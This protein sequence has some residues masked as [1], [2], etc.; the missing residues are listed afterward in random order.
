MIKQFFFMVCLI[1]ITGSFLLLWES[2][3]ESFSRPDSSK[4]EELP[5]ADSYMRNIKS[6]IFSL[7]G[8][9]QYALEAS[10]I[11]IFSGISELKLARP[12]LVA[13]NTNSQQ[14]QFEIKADSGMLYKNSKIFEFDGNVN[15]NWQTEEGASVLQA[16]NLA[17][18]LNDDNASAD[19]GVELNTPNSK[20]SGESLSVN[21]V[22]KILKIESRV[23]G[24]HDSI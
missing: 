12:L 19:G 10:E 6:F 20:I 13:Y 15:A 17:Y 22:S 4:I 1:V 5:S 16:G 18:S 21:F 9:K 3:P 14:A 8:T 23:R 7:D 2:P 11:A 24:I